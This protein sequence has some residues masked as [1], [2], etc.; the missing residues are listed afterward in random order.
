M[1]HS[2]GILHLNLPN[3]GRTLGLWY[4]LNAPRGTA[5]VNLDLTTKRDAGD[6][7]LMR[8]GYAILFI[9]WQG[10]LAD[11]QASS[12]CMRRSRRKMGSRSP[13]RCA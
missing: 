11:G 12:A 5:V 3:R 8:R 10:D 4:N 7:F 2:N 9:G 1:E 13:A 6:G